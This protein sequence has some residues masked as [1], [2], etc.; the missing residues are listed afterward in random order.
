MRMRNSTLILTA[1]MAAAS[2]A[3]NAQSANSP[4]HRRA[5]QSVVMK[6]QA[7]TIVGMPG[8]KST[9][10]PVKGIAPDMQANRRTAQA[11]AAMQRLKARAMKAREAA[12]QKW[13]PAKETSYMLDEDEA[14][15]AFDSQNT[16]KYDGN[17]RV[18]NIYT[19][20]ADNSF[21][22]TDITYTDEGRMLDQTVYSSADGKEYTGVQRLS[23]TYDE[24]MP[25]FYTFIGYYAWNTQ[26]GT[27]EL[28]DQANKYSY[29]RDADQNITSATISAPYMGE[30]EDVRRVTN[31]VDPATKQINSFKYESYGYSNNG[32]LAWNEDQYFTN[33]KWD[34]TNGQV[35]SEYENDPSTNWTNNGNYLQSATLSYTGAD[36]KVSDEG[37]I[38][39]TYGN[40][41]SYTEVTNYVYT[42]EYDGSVVYQVD[43]RDEY[44]VNI[45]DDNGSFEIEYKSWGDYNA[46]GIFTDDEIQFHEIE[47][48]QYDDHGNLTADLA[49]EKSDNDDDDDDDELD[50]PA[51]KVLTA[52]SDDASAIDATDATRYKSLVLMQGGLNAYQY[53]ASHGDAVKQQI[54]YD[55]DGESSFVPQNKIVVDEYVALA[56]TGINSVAADNDSAHIAVYTLEGVKIATPLD[57]APRGTYIVKKGS[58]VK[59][60]VKE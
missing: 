26:S 34:K 57:Q 51:A 53:D 38:S 22:R 24:V 37:D 32:K 13:V 14:Q 47:R 6:N 33:I 44:A 19:E 2:T 21:N 46:D 28:T 39:I 45:T 25:S 60:I 8:V 40:D 56:T 42:E 7:Q 9:F 35:A 50:A 29:K 58:S 48:V 59:K 17:G 10:S 41:G 27:W 12:A 20:D 49:Y 18:A 31:T 16:Y 36:G 4:I 1:A 54:S 11:R 23:R 55:Y 5:V 52:G 3:A 43:C 15:W 30:W